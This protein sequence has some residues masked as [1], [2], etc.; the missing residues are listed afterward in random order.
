MIS[1]D[2]Q[3]TQLLSN[4]NNKGLFGTDGEIWM[5]IDQ[6]TKTIK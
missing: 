5:D 2:V 4:L 3:Y 6:Q 1:Q